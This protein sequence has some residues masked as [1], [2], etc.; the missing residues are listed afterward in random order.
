MRVDAV[1]TAEKHLARLKAIPAGEFAEL[2]GVWLSQYGFDGFFTA[3][4]LQASGC[5]SAGASAAYVVFEAAL[6][7]GV[8]P[9]GIVS[10]KTRH[11]ARHCDMLRSSITHARRISA[12]FRIGGIVSESEKETDETDMAAESL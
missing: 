8:R 5:P 6:H 1:A 3:E 4:Q 10:E 11:T 7:A 12:G 2:D 9:M